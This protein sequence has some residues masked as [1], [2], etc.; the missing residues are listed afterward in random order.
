MDTIDFVRR[1]RAAECSRHSRNKLV[2]LQFAA[3]IH[4]H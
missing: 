3:L 1:V 4:I 2:V